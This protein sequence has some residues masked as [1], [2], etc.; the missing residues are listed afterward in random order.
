MY[1]DLITAAIVDE[2]GRPVF[3][4]RDVEKMETSQFSA[5]GNAVLEL[6]SEEFANFQRSA[7]SKP[8]Q[9]TN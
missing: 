7:A 2:E 6:H 3:S 1:R 8:R 9:K 5:L 4:A